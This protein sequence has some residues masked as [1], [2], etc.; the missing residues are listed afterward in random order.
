MTF[1][2]LILMNAVREMLQRSFILHSSYYF[3]IWWYGFTFYTY[4]TQLVELVLPLIRVYHS[5]AVII[6]IF[7]CMCHDFRFCDAN[8]F[9][10]NSHTCCKMR[11]SN[12]S[13][14]SFCL[15]SKHD[16]LLLFFSFICVVN[17]LYYFFPPFC[18]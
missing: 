7:I 6:N 5:F 11:S 12:V 3:V 4:L 10:T 16:V 2:S 9:L 1:N 17:F 14:N 18:V 15:F 13:G 8:H